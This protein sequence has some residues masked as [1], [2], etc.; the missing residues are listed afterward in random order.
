MVDKIRCSLGRRNKLHELYNLGE[1][2]SSNNTIIKDMIL[3]AKKIRLGSCSVINTDFYCEDL[4]IIF[5]QKIDIKICTIKTLVLE[6][7]TLMHAVNAEQV[8]IIGPYNKPVTIPIHPN[9]KQV[10]KLDNSVTLY[11]V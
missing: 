5:S 4:I 3:C 8:I 1:W 10:I 11:Q 2:I 9:T 6:R 7:S